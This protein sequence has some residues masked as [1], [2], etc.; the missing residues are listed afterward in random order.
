MGPRQ[1]SPQLPIPILLL[2]LLILFSGA[3][4]EEDDEEA[5]T[6]SNHSHSPS[7]KPSP[8]SPIIPPSSA[9]A[10]SLLSMSN[11]DPKQL[12]AL[13]SMGFSVA[14]DPC[15]SPSPHDNATACDSAS[16]FRHL[17]SLRLSNCSSDLDL[18]PTALRALSTLRSLSFLRCP[19]PPINRLPSP[20]SSS[21]RSFS[22]ISSFHRLSGVLLSGLHNLTEL[23]VRDVPITASGP[24]VIFSQMRRL[25]SATVSNANL[26]GQIPRHWHSLDLVQLDLS[27]N[28]LK[29]PVPGSISV[30]ES[31]ESLNLSSNSLTGTLPV[32]IGDLIFLRNASFARNSLSGPIPETMSAMP[33]LSHLDLSFNQFNGS[34]PV[35][36]SEM[37]LLKHLNLESNNFQ[38]V[39]PFN[40]SFIK[41][42]EVFKIGG[43]SNLCYNRS[44]LSSK[45][46][47]G[48][49]ACDKY[50]LPVSPPPAKSDK[51]DSVSD[52]DYDGEDGGGGGEENAGGGHHGPNKLVLGV[53][54]GLSCLAFLV[55]FLFF[56]SK[57]FG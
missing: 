37:K 12:N 2:T 17:I 39:I 54:I 15:G 5:C 28:S 34:V 57:I 8:A 29:G 24:F 14:L 21:L 46:N 11:L 36:I 13:Q 50:G 49:A 18:S 23:I 6:A 10:R 44:L 55:F 26:S 20:L 38:G 45:L 48:I 40:A 3:A 25:R 30:L 4:N 33:I 1:G 52:Y 42:L 53:A 41:R 47:L 19:I 43:N 9:A 22:C 7:P 35:F 31:L 16:P 56:L 51:D 27:L 32:D